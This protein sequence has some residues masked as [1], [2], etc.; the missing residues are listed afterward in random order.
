MHQYLKLAKVHRILTFKQSDGLKKYIDFNTD[1]RKNTANSSEK[2]LD[3][4]FGKTVGN[5][6]NI[7]NFKLVNNGKDYVRYVSKPSFVS[8][9][10]FS[11]N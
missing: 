4:V 1:K 2:D 5:L 8:H 11:E 3:S 6:R 10:I 9:K 7:I